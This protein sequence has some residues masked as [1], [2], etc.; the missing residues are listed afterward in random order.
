MFY[1]DLKWLIVASLQGWEPNSL[2]IFHAKMLCEENILDKRNRSSQG[3]RMNDHFARFSG[4]QPIL[5]ESF[6]HGVLLLTKPTKSTL[7]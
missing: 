4:R 1:S 3:S 5:N 7:M 2:N 6:F